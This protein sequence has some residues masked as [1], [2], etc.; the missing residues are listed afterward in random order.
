MQNFN[1][2]YLRINLLYQ[3]LRYQGTS[4]VKQQSKH[5]LLLVIELFLHQYNL[6]NTIN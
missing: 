6:R 3:L 1:W 4:K 5:V 2:Q